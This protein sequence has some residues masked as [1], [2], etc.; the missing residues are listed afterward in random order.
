MQFQVTNISG[1]VNAAAA[2][3]S[4]QEIRS[5]NPD[6]TATPNPIPVSSIQLVVPLTE[7]QN[8]VVGEVYELTFK[9][10]GK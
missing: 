3:L 9:K 8:Y 6:D 4:L 10:V 2:T 5:D 1:S 7:A